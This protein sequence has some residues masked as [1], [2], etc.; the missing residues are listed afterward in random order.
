MDYNH[1]NQENNP[2][3]CGE[4]QG[5]QKK[6]ENVSPKIKFYST[7]ENKLIDTIDNF[8][9]DNNSEI[10]LK[11]Y[12]HKQIIRDDK[13]VMNINNNF[14]TQSESGELIANI[15][16]QSEMIDRHTNIIHPQSLTDSDSLIHT[17]NNKKTHPQSYTHEKPHDSFN[18]DL[19]LVLNSSYRLMKT[20]EEFFYL[21]I[22]LA[23]WLCLIFSEFLYGVSQ[24]KVHIISDSFFN[25][26]KSISILITVFSILFT[27]VFHF[28]S[29][30]LKN[31]IELIS[32][33]S[34]IIF[35]LIVS[36]YMCLQALHIITETNDGDMPEHSHHADHE[37]DEK[38]TINFFKNF[39]IFKIV[40]D[41]VIILNLSD[42]ILHPSIQIKLFLWKKSH[43]WKNLDEFDLDN[44]KESKHLIK[45]WNNHFENMNALS[46]NMCSDLAS[47]ILFLIW[48]YLSKDQHF[49][50]AYCIISI[51]NLIIVIVLI[52]PV[53]NSLFR[54]L[55]QGK[56]E[57]YESFYQKMQTEISYYEGCLGIKEIKIWMTAQNDIKCKDVYFNLFHRLY[58]NLRSE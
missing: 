44:L 56:T 30:F 9:I 10:N 29:V 55:M 20:N 41:V 4:T 3:Y 50:Y 38:G 40:V 14:S 23:I 51:I 18:F 32:A 46:I 27:R 1:E 16:E 15:K 48:F 21:V 12:K 36:M 24:S 52:N 53:L 7:Y 19:N 2:G 13:Q 31:R 22:F 42:Y 54:I 34:N 45:I 35:L 6:T 47:S 5:S 57:V 33:L 43:S 39:F 17:D 8:K 25:L 58:T 28:N 49:E 26:F 11:S 37:G